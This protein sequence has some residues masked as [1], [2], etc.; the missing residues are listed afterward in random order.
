MPPDVEIKQLFSALFRCFLA[1]GLKI[2]NADRADACFMNGAFQQFLDLR[3]RHVYGL[4]GKRK[5]LSHPDAYEYISVAAAGFESAFVLL[6]LFS[7]LVRF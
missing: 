2:H 5:D 1:T 7:G 6:S 4:F 3:E